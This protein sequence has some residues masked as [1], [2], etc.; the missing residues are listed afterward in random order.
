MVDRR[1]NSDVVAPTSRASPTCALRTEATAIANSSAGRNFT[2]RE[3]RIRFGV[4]VLAPR[5]VKPS[6]TPTLAATLLSAL[7]ATSNDEIDA[8]TVTAVS[9]FAAVRSPEPCDAAPTTSVEGTRSGSAPQ[10]SARAAA[11]PASTNPS[12]PTIRSASRP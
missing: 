8:W 10:K 6:R 5:T 4:C 7:A 12:L 2:D 9:E 11:A 3:V 1:P